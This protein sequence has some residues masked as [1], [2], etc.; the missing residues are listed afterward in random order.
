M[1]TATP[2]PRRTKIDEGP[3]TSTA[4]RTTQGGILILLVFVAGAAS[5]AVELAA[6]RLLA[7]YF[8][9]SLFVWAN[10]IGLILLY[11]SVGYYVGGRVADRYP[12]PSVLYSLT[13][14]SSLLIAL[15]PVVARPILLWSQSAF[16][17]YSIGVFY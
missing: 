2:S 10:L 12:F 6:S 14:V 15:I 7:P 13:A 3:I 9:T 17:T 8:G 11:L 16:S 5:L 1:S 4:G